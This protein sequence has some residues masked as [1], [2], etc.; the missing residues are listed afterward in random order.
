M[1]IYFNMYG[2]FACM[3]I[4]VPHA[5]SAHGEQKRILN[6]LN[7]RHRWLLAA[8]WVLGVESRS[9]ERAVAAPALTAEPLHY[10]VFY[11]Q[12]TQT[13]MQNNQI[14]NI[15][16]ST[17]SLVFPILN[18]LKSLIKL[19]SYNDNTEV[20]FLVLLTSCKKSVNIA[21]FKIC[22]ASWLK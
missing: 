3:H 22:N 16:V 7:S 17:L 13:I 18:C 11:Q 10:L 5:H 15:C 9:C 8:M 19:L 14:L 1:V 21:L 4:C 20:T 6:S 12:T 2:Y